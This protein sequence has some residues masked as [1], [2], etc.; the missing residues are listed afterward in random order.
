WV[1]Y[2]FQSFNGQ[3]DS[4]GR[5]RA[6]RCLVDLI[7]VDFFGHVTTVGLTATKAAIEI[8]HIGRLTQLRC[9]NLDGSSVSDTGLAHFGGL[10][11]LAVVSL[12]ATRGADAGMAHLET[13]PNLVALHRDGSR[14]TEDGVKRLQRALPGLTITR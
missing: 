3:W 10:T 11:N 1:E 2:D 5:P 9:L 7:G 12:Q 8:A 13:L 14:V 4:E 6:P